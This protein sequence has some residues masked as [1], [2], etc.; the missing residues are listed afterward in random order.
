MG[1]T[2][3]VHFIHQ[4]GLQ[5]LADRGGS[6]KESNAHVAAE[7]PRSD[8][9]HGPRGKVIIDA[10]LAAFSAAHVLERASIRDPVMQLLAPNTERL[11]SRLPWTCTIAVERDG[12]CRNEESR[13]GVGLS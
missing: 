1:D 4:S 12:E 10:G 7:D 5:I 9:R 3:Q 13:H 2:G 11:L 8:A 6:A